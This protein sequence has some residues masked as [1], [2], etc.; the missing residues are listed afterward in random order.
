LRQSDAPPARS[1]A[2]FDGS[3][4][5]GA[6]KFAEVPASGRNASIG[7]ALSPPFRERTSCRNTYSP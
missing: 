4:T 5:K 1:L 3:S 2:G 7:V 6:M